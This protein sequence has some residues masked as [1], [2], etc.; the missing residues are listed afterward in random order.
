[1]VIRNFL[2][3]TG[4]RALPATTPAVEGEVAL[5]TDTEQPARLGMWVLG[6]GFGGFLLWAGLA[7]LDEGV[8]TQGMVT[9][10]TKRKAVQHLS[11]GII[12][13]VFVKEGQFVKAGEPLLAI[14]NAVSQANYASVRHHYLTLRAMEGRLVAEQANHPKIDF[15]PDLLQG[16][17]DPLIKQTMDNQQSLF[18]AR[19]SAFQAE[20][21]GIQESIQGQEASIQGYEGML[22][23]RKAQQEYLQEELKGLR[24]LVKEG[25]APRNKQLELER[26]AAESAGSIADL[27]GNILRARRAIAELKLRGIQRAQEYRKEVDSQLADIRREVQADAEKFK[28]SSDDLARTTIRAPAEGQVV[29][30]VAQTVGGVISP[31][32]KLMDIVPQKEAL[33]L[34]T[35]VPP[36]MIDR[37]QPG[38]E[39]DVRFSSF[40]H[41]PQLVVEGK[42]DSISADLITEPQ[43]NVSYYLAR[44]SVTPK[45]MKELGNRQMQAGMP[46]EV[47]IKT[48]ERTVLTYLLHPLLKRMA[49]SMKEE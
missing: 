34:E 4:L 37:V 29:G 15:H 47:V 8:P 10:D 2:E 19:R 1:M 12:K 21:Q 7:P 44:I 24:E 17:T 35:R 25:Y 16:A 6:V 14:D 11:G 26:M 40:A 36:H 41:S 28:A 23:G 39:T 42:V 18:L 32:Q 49:A 48:G 43:T 5:P 30:L 20:Q 13:Q 9:I 3:K 27:Q 33:L 38:K 45:G 46:A 31:G 22:S